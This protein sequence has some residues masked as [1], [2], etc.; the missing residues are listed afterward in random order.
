[1]LFPSQEDPMTDTTE[2]FS[3]EERAA[4]KDRAQEVKRARKG[5]PTKEDD[6]RDVMAKIDELAEPERTTAHR[7]AEI[8]AAAVPDLDPK[9]WYGMPAWSRNGKNLCFFQSA[10]KFKTR[11]ATIGFSDLAQLDDGT[12]WPNAYAL[13][14]LTPEVE[15]RIAALVRQAAGV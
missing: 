9:L 2:T 13:T 4:M 7:I 15:E 12:F 6:A 10:T 11:Y 3:A 1:V 8:I 14:E 5:K